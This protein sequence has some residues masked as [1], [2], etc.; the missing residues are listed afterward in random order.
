MCEIVSKISTTIHQLHIK[1]KL[2]AVVGPGT[3]DGR[4]DMNGEIFDIRY[5]I[6]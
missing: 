5:I 3:N 1:S 6:C 4:I 2:V